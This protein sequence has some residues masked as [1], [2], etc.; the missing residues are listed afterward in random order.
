MS[1]MIV[2]RNMNGILST[3]NTPQ[4]AQFILSL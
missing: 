1:K 4:G 2:E 3:N